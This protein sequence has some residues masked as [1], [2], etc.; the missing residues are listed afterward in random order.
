MDDPEFAAALDCFGQ[1][2]HQIIKG[3]ERRQADGN[4]V[5]VLKDGF[6]VILSEYEKLQSNPDQT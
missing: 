4:N 2:L 3:L 6:E 1:D 5:Q